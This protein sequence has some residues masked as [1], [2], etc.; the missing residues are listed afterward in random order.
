MA[1][2]RRDTLAL[3]K[4]SLKKKTVTL[5]YSASSVIQ[6]PASAV[7]LTSDSFDVAGGSQTDIVIKLQVAQA[8]C[9][10]LDYPIIHANLMFP[11]IGRV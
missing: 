1:L 4:F 3:P 6:N 2:L 5:G 9:R 11:R 10:L 8:R 7:A